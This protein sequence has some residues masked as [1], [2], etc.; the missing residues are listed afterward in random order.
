M[1][2]IKGRLNRHTRLRNFVYR[3]FASG[4]NFNFD[5][6]EDLLLRNEC[7]MMQAAQQLRAH[8]PANDFQSSCDGLIGIMSSTWFLLV[9]IGN[10]LCMPFRPYKDK[11]SILSVPLPVIIL[12]Q[13]PEIVSLFKSGLDADITLAFRSLLKILNDYC[14]NSRLSASAAPATS[15]AQAQQN[16]A[17]ANKWFV[18]NILSKCSSNCG[19]DWRFASTTSLDAMN[20]DI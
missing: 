11:D 5:T 16:Y 3:Y 9:R 7:S 14:V 17:D 8:F 4:T 2:Q 13:K 1:E 20:F 15:W 18:A 12:F 10:K 6:I 19:F